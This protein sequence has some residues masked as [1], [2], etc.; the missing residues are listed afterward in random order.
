MRTIYVWNTIATFKLFYVQD[1]TTA[2]SINL[3]IIFYVKY[4]SRQITVRDSRIFQSTSLFLRLE[5]LPLY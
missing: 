2:R 3:Q 4:E 5:Y 1:T